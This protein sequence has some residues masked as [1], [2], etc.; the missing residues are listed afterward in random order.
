[1]TKKAITVDNLSKVYRIGVKGA[2][3]DSIGRAVLDFARSPFSNYKKYRSLYRFSPDELAGNYVGD[4]ILWA[5]KDV[6]FS[7]DQGEVVGIVGVNGAGKSTLLKVVSNITPPTIGSIT[8]RGRVSSLLEVGTGFHP[9]LTGRENVYLN[10]TILGMRKKE[11]DSKFDEIVD[12]SGVEKFLDTPVKR[13]SMGMRVRLAF[14]VAAHL[15][16]EILIIDEV[17][18]VGDAEFQKKCLSKMEDVGKEGRT[19]LFVSHNMAAVTRLC[20]RGILLSG[21][22]I[23][24]DSDAHTIVS[25]YLTSGM[26]TTASREW[27]NIA[28]APGDDAVRLRSIRIIDTNGAVVEGADIRNPVGL[29][30][31]YDVLSD[32]QVL[33]PYFSLT[34]DEGVLVFSTIDQDLQWHS[35]PRRPGRYTSTAW[36]PGNLLSEGMVYV[37]VAMR[38]PHRKYRPIQLGDAI[39]FNVIDKME[40]ESARGSWVGRLSGAV[41]PMLDWTTEYQPAEDASGG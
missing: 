18:A 37:L 5:L 19:V 4:D 40:G 7:V 29:V 9:E 12:F 13:Y 8:I 31:E 15:E 24:G 34:N 27:P 30:M 41:R 35:E 14:A 23:I 2:T 3:N 38:T 22:S 1:M 10:G 33:L 36:V 32:D 6:S 28:E 11:V 25:T 21:G 16:P 20:S 17:L 26:G 39:A